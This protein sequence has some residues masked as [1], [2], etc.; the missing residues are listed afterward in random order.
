MKKPNEK[1]N[2]CKVGFIVRNV[3]RAASIWQRRVATMC[4]AGHVHK[5]VNAFHFS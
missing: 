3:A 2:K 1:H 4:R 5:E